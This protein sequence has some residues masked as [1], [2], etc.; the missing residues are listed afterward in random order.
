MSLGMMWG[1]CQGDRICACP[2]RNYMSLCGYTLRGGAGYT[3]SVNSGVCTLGGDVTCGGTAL[4]NISASF[5][6]A[7]VFLSPNT[8]SGIVGVGLRR[9]WV[10][11]AVACVD[12]S[13]DNIIGN[14]SFSG[15]TM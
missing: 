15:K 8:A 5:L 11:S 7:A 14:V 12:A 10:R 1:A 4:L 6:R 3:S 9:A 2:G 13:F